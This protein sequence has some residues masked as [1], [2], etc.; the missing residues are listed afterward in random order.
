MMVMSVIPARWHQ[1]SGYQSRGRLA[2]GRSALGSEVGLE[3]KVLRERPGPQRMRAWRA[4]VG[5]VVAWGML[6]GVMGD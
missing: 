1:V 6:A 4:G 2:R 5:R 3:V